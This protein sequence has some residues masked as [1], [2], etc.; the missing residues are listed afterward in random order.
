VP[1]TIQK[2][3]VLLLLAIKDFSSPYQLK[4]GLGRITSAV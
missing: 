1:G 3:L 2:H 4:G